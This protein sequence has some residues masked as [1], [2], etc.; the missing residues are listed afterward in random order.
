MLPVPQEVPLRLTA[1]SKSTSPQR[2]PPLVA[3]HRRLTHPCRLPFLSSDKLHY[4][5]ASTCTPTFTHTSQYCPITPS[6]LSFRMEVSCFVRRCRVTLWIVSYSFLSCIS[7]H[8]ISPLRSL[9]SVER[10]LFPFPSHYM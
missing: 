1:P 9:W 10:L 5:T 8:F 3:A 4:R 6:A 2:P 7:I